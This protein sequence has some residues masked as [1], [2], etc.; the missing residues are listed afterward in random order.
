MLSL[1]RRAGSIA[2]VIAAARQYRVPPAKKTY[3]RGVSAWTRSTKVPPPRELENLGDE[4]VFKVFCFTWPSRK[5]QAGP[6]KKVQTKKVQT[7]L[8][9]SEKLLLQSSALLMKSEKQ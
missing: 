7:L 8:M 5:K 1:E 3:C 6:T 2:A 9:K 4:F